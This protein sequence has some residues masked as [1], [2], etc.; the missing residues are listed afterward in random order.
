MRSAGTPIRP[1]RTEDD[2]EKAVVRIQELINADADTPE[3][4]ELDILATLVDAYEAKHHAIDAPDPIA[5]IEFRMEQEGWTR[6]DLEPLIGSRA[7]V[8]E[9]LNRKRSLTL[10][11]IRRVKFGLGISADLLIAPVQ[12]KVNARKAV[13]SSKSSR[14][15]KVR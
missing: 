3:G 6:K 15:R 11:M 10:K 7:R 12:H 5:A 1:I 2:H 14:T 8:S 9:I 13:H 4:D